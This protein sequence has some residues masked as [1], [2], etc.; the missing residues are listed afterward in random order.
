MKVKL[1][2]PEKVLVGF[3]KREVALI[4]NCL[5]EACHGVIMDRFIPAHI[6]L[7]NMLESAQ[8]IEREEVFYNIKT[9]TT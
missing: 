1:K 9:P 5:Y 4:I 3:N 7:M 6:E 8:R 2:T